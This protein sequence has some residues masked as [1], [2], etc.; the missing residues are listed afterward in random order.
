MA[1]ELIA[2]AAAGLTSPA[3]ALIERVS[4]AVGGVVRPWQIQRVAEAEAKGEAKKALILAESEIEVTDLQRRAAFRW[5]EEETKNQENIESITGQALPRLNDDAEPEKI[6]ND[7]LR[8]F[9]DKCRIVSDEQMQDVWARILA[10]EANNPG[11]FSRKTIN[12][13]SD[14]S[15]SDADLF[16]TVCSHVWHFPN[17]VFPI[18]LISD[19]FFRE[20]GINLYALVH[21]ESIGL[22]ITDSMGFSNRFEQD[23]FRA[24]YFERSAEI[25][26]AP[27]AEGQL[28]SGDILLTSAGRE[29]GSICTLEP[30]EGF[31]ELM[32]H[33]WKEDS[34]VESVKVLGN[35]AE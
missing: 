28:S 22:F 32:C 6:E 16:V 29:L 3:T 23:T 27:S 13:L 31:F 7:F 4:D 5:L 8:N 24:T 11:R 10:G 15:K 30:I 20:R 33:K 35:V 21:L 18:V 14:M 2:S 26:L 19:E 9:F 34:N 1:G 12:V 25:T 17:A